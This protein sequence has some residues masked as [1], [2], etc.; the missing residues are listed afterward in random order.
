MTQAQRQWRKLMVDGPV[1]NRRF[2]R[3]VIRQAA[4]ISVSVIVFF[5][6]VGGGWA[7][8]SKISADAEKAKREA[9]E[10]KAR[11]T[12]TQVQ[13]D[14][15]LIKD[16]LSVLAREQQTISLF[17]SGAEDTALIAA[18]EEKQSRFEQALKLRYIKP[19]SYELDNAS[20]P[21]FSYASIDMLKKAET[22]S[23]INT[24]VH[25]FGSPNEHIVMVERVTNNAFELIGLLHL[26]ISINYFDELAKDLT[27]EGGYAE[28]TQR[29]SGRTLVLTKIG[30]ATLRHGKATTVSVNDTHWTIA[31]WSAGEKM[32]AANE[33]T[34]SGLP[35]IPIIVLLLLIGGAVYFVMQK[36]GFASA[37]SSSASNSGDDLVTYE[38]A[39]RA[40]AEGAHPGVEHMIPQLPKGDRITANL[41]PVSQG[42]ASDDATMMAA[43]LFDSEADTVEPLADEVNQG[44]TDKEDKR[45]Q[46]APVIFRAYD[47]RGIAGETLT[48][49][50]VYE[51]GR[52][53]GSMAHEQGQ[54]A[55]VVAR[56]GRISSPMLGD[57]LIKGLRSTGRDV[58]DIGVV[59]TPVLYFA[60]YH[61]ETGSGVMLT[62][63]HNAAEYNGL[64]IML[65]GKTLS[66][67]EIK[68]IQS[69]A[70]AGEH[71]SGQGDLRHTDISAD[72][73]RRISE[74]IPVALGS[75]L[76]IV[77]D[78]GNGVA[79]T[80]APQ[81][82][83]A[84]GHDVIE[85]YCDI[86]GTFPN[87]HPDP[88]QPENL[89]ELIE[90]VKAEGADIGFAFDGD[91]DRLGVVD[92]EGNIIWPDRQLML[93]AK[94]V[95]SR[96]QGGKIIF[97]VK[98]SRYLK[99]IIE[100]NGGEPLMWKTGHS[101]IKN[102]MREVDSPLAGEMSGHIFFKERWYGFDDAL[103]TSA[104]FVEIFGNS[105]GT[106]TE[107]FAELPDGF[108]TP[109]LRLPVDEEMHAS[110]MEE[111]TKKIAV[112]NAEIID[113]DGLRIEYSDGWGLARPS[114][115]SPYII[116]RFEGESEAV[117]ERIKSEFRG[118]IQLVLP[119]VKI[120]F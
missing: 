84:V 60:T 2:S 59:P 110:F 36:R 83:N 111:L 95:L 75:S 112:S 42:L 76:K 24:E 68:E 77:V 10:A 116:L 14:L 80:L 91:G 15:G 34:S 33:E 86:D 72:Y 56:D 52:A 115:T 102:K 107:L 94:D 108:S 41:K 97:D 21:P 40:I 104:R 118:A 78:C 45:L 105:E 66:G 22:R 114:N 49:E 61:L 39:V 73:V 100:T 4:I 46:I 103:Y 37:S 89:Q 117:L 17:A 29:A 28:L 50:V 47:I 3:R 92:A 67:D 19:K 23:Q 18:A 88:S 11:D 13:K 31:Y 53:I 101:F 44:E 54:Q 57:S 8:Y 81:L 109:E 38:G 55:L 51:I 82:L 30:D 63:S 119:D 93:L 74:D 6:V 79:G 32:V 43:P 27:I 96:N 7:L 113:I 62:G 58:I 25:L 48:E 5:V 65:A 98:C 106:P 26:S 99:S 12:A 87:H 90:R 16:R 1:T 64:K 120:P 69:R 20:V 70:V 9:I 35:I 85:M 71:N